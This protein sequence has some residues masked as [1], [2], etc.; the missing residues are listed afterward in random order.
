MIDTCSDQITL[1]SVTGTIVDGSG[2]RAPVP[3]GAMYH[4]TFLLHYIILP[5]VIFILIFILFYFR[6]RWLVQVPF[7][8]PTITFVFDELNIG[9]YSRIRIF[10]GA[11]TTSPV[12][13]FK[14]LI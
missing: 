4:F 8:A 3:Y 14:L 7:P 2:N 12:S 6:C 13:Y 10:D 5:L 11:T 1:N 9:S